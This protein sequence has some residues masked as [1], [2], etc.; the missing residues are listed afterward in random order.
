MTYI[1]P[2]ARREL[3]EIER[4]QNRND[5]AKASDPDF[6]KR[7]TKYADRYRWMAGDAMLALARAGVDPDDD[8]ARE[9]A[10]R[11]A[12]LRHRS[13]MGWYD[14]GDV[15]RGAQV[16]SRAAA[17]GR[18]IAAAANG[19][20]GVQLVDIGGEQVQM[21]YEPTPGS[22][23]I[24]REDPGRMG[25]ADAS[26][27]LAQSQGVPSFITRDDVEFA[28]DFTRLREAQAAG[29]EPERLAFLQGDVTYGREAS[30]AGVGD[31]S[32]LMDV[33]QSLFRGAGIAM[34]FPLR[35]AQGL[36]RN[37]V[38]GNAS[39]GGLYDPAA[40]AQTDLGIIAEQL[41]RGER[42]D[43]GSGF[44]VD[45]ESEVAKERVRRERAAGSIDGHAIT[46]GRW[47]A[48][49]VTPEGSVPYYV[50]SGLVDATIAIKADPAAKLA[51]SLATTF[52]NRSL[53]IRRAGGIDGLRKTVAQDK[54]M[55]FLNSS[56]GVKLREFLRDTDIFDVIWKATDKKIPVKEVVRLADATTLDEVDDILQPLLGIAVREKPHL[57]FS[58]AANR[59]MSLGGRKGY[60]RLA[61]MMPSSVIDRYDINEA[62]EQVDRYMRN[63]AIDRN[64]IAEFT[65]RM[66]RAGSGHEQYQVVKDMQD[67]V[68]AKLIGKGVKP[69]DA[70]TMTQ[71][72]LD[73]DDEFRMYVVD[74]IG[75]KR[76]VPGVLTGGTMVETPSPHLYSEVVG[77]MIP[78]PDAREIRRHTS[79][80]APILTNPA[81]E[82]PRAWLEWGIARWKESVLFRLAY[83]TRVLGEEQF[84]QAA[85]GRYS[86][87]N[88]PLSYISLLVGRS[89]GGTLTDDL[90]SEVDEYQK[91]LVKGSAGFRDQGQ[92]LRFWTRYGRD[93]REFLPSWADEL[94]QLHADP[95]AVALIERA[96]L[97]AVRDAMWD[98]DLQ[99]V[100]KDLMHTH[101]GLATRFGE[102]GSDAWVDLTLDRIGWKTGGDGD[103]LQAIRTGRLDG[104]RI[105]DDNL[106]LNNDFVKALKKRLDA[107]IGP[108]KVKGQVRAY[109][110]AG[111]PGGYDAAVERLFGYLMGKPAN[112][113]SRNPAWQG[114]YWQR[115]GELLP[116]ADEATKAKVIAR[117]RELRLDRLTIR[118]M[119]KLARQ[120]TGDLAFEHI[121]DLAKG[122][123]LDETKKLLYDL[124]DRGQFFDAYRL[125]FPFGEAWKEMVTTWGR[126]LT[127]R[128]Q[129]I[130]RIHQAMTTG[131]QSGFFHKDE[132]GDE[133][134]VYPFT[135]WI[136]EKFVGV[137]I[138]FKGRV[139]GLSLMTEVLPGT[140]PV[141]QI[142]V[143][144]VLPDNTEWDWLREWVLPFGEPGGD[145]FRDWMPP[146]LQKFATALV[147]T[148]E[149]TKAK[150]STTME[151]LRYGA[152]VG[153]YDLSTPEGIRNAVED[154]EA[155]ST[156]LF[157]IRGFVAFGAPSA[158]SPEFVVE[159]KDGKL[160]IIAKLR[161]EY[162]QKAEKDFD[163]DYDAAMG[164]FLDRYG[165][166]LTPV[167]QGK[168][169]SVVAGA[170]VSKEGMNW[171]R[172]HPEYRKNFPHVYGYFAPQGGELD[173]DAYRRVF[174]RDERVNITP[175]QHA[176]LANDRIGRYLYQRAKE[177]VTPPP[178][179]DGT[180][181]S[182]TDEARAYLRDVRA[183]LRREFPGFQQELNL[184]GRINPADEEGMAQ[185]LGELE[186]ALRDP[187]L[188]RSPQG[189]AL[190][191]YLQARAQA[192]QIG[193]QRGLSE[194]S[195][196][197]S[198]SMRDVRD[199]LRNAGESLS[200]Q[201]PDFEPLWRDIFERELA[202]D[203]DEV[204]AA[205]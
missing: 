60:V 82:K 107:G 133:V 143:A 162:R 195:F 47:A 13:G 69:S 39:L 122:W 111:K 100:R 101:P 145:T 4:F 103:L 35:Y 184:P 171:E 136:N 12:V 115:A 119:E 141:V 8:V 123:A 204:K 167:L 73:G 48:H 200:T 105:S 153:R 83:P 89:G 79:A 3:N 42:V 7:L 192:E 84:R 135:E 45:P 94:G 193:K 159:D 6:V 88:H 64:T 144:A 110:K 34:D 125:V 66:A 96:D 30:R 174:E 74:D 191:A 20:T 178:R 16:A 18:S 14:K 160:Q 118:N 151:L 182:L 26:E 126:I 137:P 177:S 21:P 62:V 163:G 80:L 205:A 5:A 11:A 104:A 165:W 46:P 117:A 22:S 146:W 59:S 54:V 93:Q 164:W 170:P 186:E 72:F 168:S 70:R 109:T 31:P 43:T 158:P 29:V 139:A 77:R 51:S 108:D 50:L 98:G 169:F 32:A 97:Q 180:V 128:P 52:E 55:S 36:F 201:R 58:A 40:V 95:V 147:P 106:T 187:E 173:P 41:I 120:G 53:F 157:L 9:A 176:R 15:V 71:M 91:A 19:P 23:V 181:P 65:E 179:S 56:E 189:E 124:H 131:R 121:D 196:T 99:W 17:Q 76:S 152:S 1:N 90:L 49:W 44:F 155:R 92:K 112:Y 142:P 148:E 202:D 130:R 140:G 149:M 27:R 38:S 33:G 85:S 114:Y 78:L 63:A 183:Q 156:K 57:A 127:H 154:A 129:S 61:G 87:F 24:G 138:P 37:V 188:A 199:Y 75:R 81:I 10:R 68:A 190:S 203:A 2:D 161:E 198:N 197:T 194:R 134:F 113:L 172:D 67:V 185:L 102:N 86:F 28:Q 166:N 175:E 150:A 116:F 25:T 132:Y